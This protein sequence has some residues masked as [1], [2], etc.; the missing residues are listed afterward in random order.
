MFGNKKIQK[1]PFEP[2]ALAAINPESAAGKLNAALIIDYAEL[3][4]NVDVVLRR[5]AE[6][7]LNA[8]YLN[9]L[10]VFL[11]SRFKVLVGD[12]GDNAKHIENALFESFRLRVAR[13]N[14]LAERAHF[15]KDA[16]NGFTLFFKLGNFRRNSV[17]FGF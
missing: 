8:H 10:V 2:R 3:V 5:K 7:G 9:H 12:V 11:F 6:F 4:A 15:G 14:F 13:G 16:V 1:R 17:A